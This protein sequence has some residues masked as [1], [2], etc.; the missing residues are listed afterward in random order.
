[1]IQKKNKNSKFKKFYFGLRI[2]EFSPAST[3]LKESIYLDVLFDT[4]GEAAYKKIIDDELLFPSRLPYFGYRKNKIDEGMQVGTEG[5]I[6]YVKKNI[7][8]IFKLTLEA[9]ESESETLSY[10]NPM[11]IKLYSELYLKPIYAYVMRVYTHIVELF[12]YI[13]TSIN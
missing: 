3:Y 2:L 6:R 10:N 8:D 1:M 5:H 11:I 13:S 12:N 9:F 4:N 7:N